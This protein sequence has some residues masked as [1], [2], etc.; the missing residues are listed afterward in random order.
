MPPTPTPR[1]KRRQQPR[2]GQRSGKEQRQP[3]TRARALIPGAVENSIKQY[4]IQPPPAEQKRAPKTP[5]GHPKQEN[6]RAERRPPAGD[7]DREKRA[8][9]RGGKESRPAAYVPGR[10]AGRRRPAA[11][12]ISRAH[13][14]TIRQAAAKPGRGYPGPGASRIKRTQNAM[15]VKN[16]RE[17][18]SENVLRFDNWHLTKRNRAE[19]TAK[20]AR[21]AGRRTA[22][23]PKRG[24]WSV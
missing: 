22:G 11:A 13:A 15:S 8:A 5:A 4:H 12:E 3:L 6:T 16:A 23:A 1:E 24:A 14:V 2:R 19:M 21:N 20:L 7:N 18:A 9:A 10:T 17:I